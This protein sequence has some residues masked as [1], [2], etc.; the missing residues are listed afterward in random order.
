[1]YQRHE[2]REAYLDQRDEGAWGYRGEA[3]EEEE[4]SVSA[5]ALSAALSA[6]TSPSA[7]PTPQRAAAP[8]VVPIGEGAVTGSF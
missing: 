1:M 3:H 2:R 5:D 8:V 4:G 6:P 7:P